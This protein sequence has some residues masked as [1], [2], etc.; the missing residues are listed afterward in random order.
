MQTAYPRFNVS[1]SVSDIFG[2]LQN[3]LARSQ[4]IIPDLE[5]P[6]SRFPNTYCSTIEVEGQSVI[7][8][9]SER[10]QQ[11]DAVLREISGLNA[12]TNSIEKNYQ[13]AVEKKEKITQSINLHKGVTSTLWRVPA[14]VLSQI[15]HH[16]LPKTTSSSPSSLKAPILLTRICRRWRE[17][18]VNTPDLWCRLYLEANNTDMRRAAFCYDLWLKRSRGCP[19]SLRLGHN[20]STDV[21]RLLHPYMTRITSLRTY[22][23]CFRGKRPHLR[24]TDLPA[25]QELV[26]AEM[27]NRDIQTIPRFI[28]RLPSTMRTFKVIDTRLFFDIDLLSS[29]SPIWA[30]LTDVQIP[31]CH[32]NAFLHLLQLCPNLSSLNV[33]LSVLQSV[34]LKTFTH[35][36]LESLCV[37]NHA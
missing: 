6:Y 4:V 21:H 37:P 18:A 20:H 35:T 31:V 15:F 14:E 3:L 33:R 12:I 11:L 28:S 23:D 34:P 36:K 10:Q 24:A 8:I 13:Q 7:N 32:P 27:T 5:T 1:D 22:V 30:H 29:F 2:E 25:L 17:V 19:T 9:I 16:C 26:I